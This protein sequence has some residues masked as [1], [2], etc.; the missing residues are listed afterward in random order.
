[1]LSAY[2]AYAEGE[3][4]GG[5]LGVGGGLDGVGPSSERRHDLRIGVVA[6][7]VVVVVQLSRAGRWAC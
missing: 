2:S 5:G 4:A 3:A 6:L 7:Y 1:M